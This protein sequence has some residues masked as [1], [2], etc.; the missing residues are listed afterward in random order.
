MLTLYVTRSETQN[1]MIGDTL[2]SATSVRL[3][4]LGWRDLLAK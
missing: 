2:A 1:E 3:L 4:G